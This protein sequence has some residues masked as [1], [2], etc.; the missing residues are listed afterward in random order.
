MAAMSTYFSR[1]FGTRLQARGSRTRR[2]R[3]AKPRVQGLEDRQLLSAFARGV[4]GGQAND[5]AVYRPSNGTWYIDEAA[6]GFDTS[7]GLAVQWGTKGDIPVTNSDFFGNGHADL[8]VFRP[9]NA[10]WYIKDAITGVTASYQ[11]GMQGDVPLGASDFFGNGH[12]DLAVYHPSNG[13]WCIKDPANGQ[14]LIVQWGA[15]GDVPIAHANFDGDGR[16]DIAVFRPS[17][18]TWHILTSSTGYQASAAMHWQWGGQGDVPVFNTDINGYGWDDLVVFRPSNGVWYVLD[19]RIGRTQAFQWGTQGDVPLGAGDFFG[20]GHADLAVF[21]PSNGMWCVWDTAT[22]QTLWSR[23]GQNGD[24]PLAHADFDGDG[25]ADLAVFRPTDGSWHILTS[26]SGFTTRIDH[27]WGEG[28][29]TAVGGPAVAEPLL[30]SAAITYTNFDGDPVFASDGPKPEDVVQGQVGDCQ[31]LAVLQGIAKMDPAVLRRSISDMGNGTYAVDF[32][33][34]GY[35]RYVVVDACLPTDAYGNLVY[36][37]LGHQNSLWVALMEK[38]W[39]FDRPLSWCDPYNAALGTYGMIWGGGSHEILSE[40]DFSPQDN[41]TNVWLATCIDANNG[42]LVTV[43]T[44]DSAVGGLV[45]DH[46]YFVDS[47]NYS[48]V[49]GTWTATS[50]TLR[51]P[52]GGANEF[53]TVDESTIDM[54]MVD[55]T[56]AYV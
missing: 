40:L 22:G 11:W 42:K 13:T 20:D 6:T 28:G 34:L 33:P 51:N 18:M 38:A 14:T 12:A 5:I 31:M 8:A 43:A 54:S 17:D 15:P 41:S 9:S 46:V 53:I 32:R 4:E 47:I 3:A 29:D 23:W 30:T 49:E 50:V 16:A 45:A 27:Y 10:T 56:S 24:V 48:W 36:A 37:N 39:T 52:Y 55:E 7:R 21:R 25:R 26:S 2:S 1:A 35:D 44:G 19:P